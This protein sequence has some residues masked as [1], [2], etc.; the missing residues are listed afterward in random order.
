MR[1]SGLIGNYIVCLLVGIYITFNVVAFAFVT[2]PSSISQKAS[3]TTKSI[4][5]G[6]SLLINEEQEKEKEGEELEHISDII[7]LVQ[8]IAS[9]KAA[10]KE[11]PI[12]DFNDWH[13]S[14]K[15][16]LQ[17]RSLLI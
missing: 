2:L 6:F 11:F 8:T 17:H 15:I 10:T 13:S 16:Y 1:K 7:A 5:K 3:F 14:C 9:E 12:F 4:A